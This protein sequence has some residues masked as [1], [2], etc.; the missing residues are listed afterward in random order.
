MLMHSCVLIVCLCGCIQWGSVSLH[1]MSQYMSELSGLT[2]LCF[3]S[4]YHW[5][6]SAGRRLVSLI[7]VLDVLRTTSTLILLL[8]QLH[9]CR[10][11]IVRVTKQRGLSYIYE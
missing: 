2:A 9:S 8:L 3:T 4:Y 1:Y 10:S 6:T 7:G 5:A 11:S